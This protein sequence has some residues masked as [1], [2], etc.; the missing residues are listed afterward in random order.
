MNLSSVASCLRAPVAR[1]SL[2]AAVALAAVSAATAR[3]TPVGKP[4]MQAGM[5]IAAVYLQPVEMEPAG[6]MPAPHDSDIHLEADI[7][8]ARDNPNGFAEGDWIPYLGV[9]FELVRLGSDWKRTG[10]L[11]PTVANDGPHYGDNVRLD[12]PGKYRLTLF[13]DPPTASPDV[14]FGRHVDPET[15]VGPWFRP[16]TVSWE[17]AWA[18]A[19]KKGGY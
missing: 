2:A 9:R 13:I 16:L 12:G 19:G 6:M 5:E 1:L 4:Q 14:H 18:G 7:R 17:F 11:M 3:E 10:A 8:A 15:G